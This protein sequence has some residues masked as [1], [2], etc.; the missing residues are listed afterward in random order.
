MPN[1][2]TY[3]P[4]FDPETTTLRNITERN[5]RFH[6]LS[7]PCAAIMANS[8]P[9]TLSVQPVCS[10]T[11]WVETAKLLPLNHCVNTR[12]VSLP[13]WSEDTAQL[14]LNSLVVT[15]FLAQDFIKQIRV[16]CTGKQRN[17]QT[18]PQ[19][20]LRFIASHHTKQPLPLYKIK[21]IKRKWNI[22]LTISF[23]QYGPS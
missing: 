18:C 1:E 10:D 23:H 22:L 12:F 8:L 9:S 21:S 14:N 3:I 17:Q 19:T 6:S 4:C 5:R 20:N 16:R 2:T 13:P 7:E 11:V 15:T